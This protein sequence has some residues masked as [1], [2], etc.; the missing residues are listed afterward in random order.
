M[1]WSETVFN[2]KE[3]KTNIYSKNWKYRY[4]GANNACIQ[5]IFVIKLNEICCSLFL[6]NINLWLFNGF[7]QLMNERKLL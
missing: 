5:A 6:L 1:G 4:K 7:E 3:T 2:K